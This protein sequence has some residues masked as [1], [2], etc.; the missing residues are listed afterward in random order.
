MALAAFD[1]Q[2]PAVGRPIRAMLEERV[3]PVSPGAPEEGDA[4]SGRYHIATG[5]IIIWT[6]PFKRA[7]PSTN[8]NSPTDSAASRPVFMVSRM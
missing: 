7:W 3:S 5:L 8:M 4:V 2:S 1:R 6:A